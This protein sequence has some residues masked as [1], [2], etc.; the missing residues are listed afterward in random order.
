MKKK[1]QKPYNKR[2]MVVRQY[3]PITREWL[4]NTVNVMLEDDRK[5]IR[6]LKSANHHTGEEVDKLAKDLDFVQENLGKLVDDVNAHNTRLLNHADDITKLSEAVKQ[7]LHVVHGELSK[8]HNDMQILRERMTALNNVIGALAESTKSQFKA[9]NDYDIE[10][11]RQ[12]DELHFRLNSHSK[13]I[14]NAFAELTMLQKCTKEHVP[15]G[16]PLEPVMTPTARMW[17]WLEREIKVWE[18]RKNEQARCLNFHGASDCDMA[19][20]TLEGALS[21]LVEFSK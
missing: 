8:D 15:D 12:I 11:K 6:D 14:N 20:A 21:K 16:A 13:Q 10:L 2:P 7:E 18:D 9:S 3:I 19:K 17:E 1:P 5:D 4:I